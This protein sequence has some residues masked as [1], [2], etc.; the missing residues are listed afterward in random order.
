MRTSLFRVILGLAVVGCGESA[1][2]PRSAPP[3]ASVAPPAPKPTASEAP[4]EE[5]KKEEPRK[6]EPPPPPP[7]KTAKEVIVP[8]ATFLFSL[9]DSPDAMKAV[10]ET[11]GKKKKDEDKKKCEDEAKA[12]AAEEGIRFEK[13][14]KDG[15]WVWVS[16]GKEKDKEVVFNKI[17][18]KDPKFED[19]KVTF[20]MT[21]KDSGKRAMKFKEGD[22]SPVTEL[23]DDTTVAMMDPKKGRLVFKLKK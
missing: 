16:F 20:T 15:T 18:I 19:K 7:P 6:E 5:P 10:T 12:S 4:K 14:E 11:C 8:G 2:D 1:P 21:G 22:A 9:A 13:G 3:P 17:T 23:V